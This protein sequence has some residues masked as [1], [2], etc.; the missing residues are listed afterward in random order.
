MYIKIIN[1]D[2]VKL[3]IEDD[4]IQNFEKINFDYM[5]AIIERNG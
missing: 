4:E 3:L 5:R 2:K 1:E